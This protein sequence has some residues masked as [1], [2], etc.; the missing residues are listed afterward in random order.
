MH[1]LANEGNQI[2]V[3]LKL[4]FLMVGLFRFVCVSDSHFVVLQVQIVFEHC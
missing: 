4:S 1:A 3:L 2:K